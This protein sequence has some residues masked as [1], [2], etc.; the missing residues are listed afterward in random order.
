MLMLPQ[1]TRFENHCFL[2]WQVHCIIYFFSELLE[3]RSCVS[4][5]IYTRCFS[6]CFLRMRMFS[7]ITALW[8]SNSGNL[9]PI[10]ALV[11]LTIHIPNVVTCPNNILYDTFSLKYIIQSRITHCVWMHCL[12]YLSIYSISLAFLSLTWQSNF[13]SL[14]T[15]DFGHPKKQCFL[16]SKQ[17]LGRHLKIMQISCLLKTFPPR[18]FP[19][20]ILAGA[21]LY[22]EGCKVVS[23]DP[24]LLTSWRVFLPAPDIYWS[25]SNFLS[26]ETTCA[27]QRCQ[28]KGQAQRTEPGPHRAATL[29]QGRSTTLTCSVHWGA[30]YNSVY[31]EVV[32]SSCH[33]TVG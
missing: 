2:Y 8:L 5:H 20:M 30:V 22:R 6:M 29:A 27:P 33:G 16:P 25:N 19:S 11:T 7:Y 28:G 32:W 10:T 24:P 31:Q 15:S 3:S 23:P 9:T 13:W 21:G 1:G 17:T 26:P 14:Q 12:F 4:C 18:V